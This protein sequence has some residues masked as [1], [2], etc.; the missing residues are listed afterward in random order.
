MT[1]AES[2]AYGIVPRVSESIDFNSRV[3]SIGVASKITRKDRLR[4]LFGTRGM[5][6][7]RRLKMLA[8]IGPHE[9]EVF[10][11][12]SILVGDDCILYARLYE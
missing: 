10:P 8:S 9:G 2:N 12:N 3:I 1:V 7:E 6:A 5:S 4:H 11:T